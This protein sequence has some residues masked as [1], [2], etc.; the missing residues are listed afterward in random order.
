M[1]D[2]KYRIMSFIGLVIIV[3]LFYIFSSNRKAVNF[4]TIISGVLLQVLIGL[5]I[6]KTDT[7]LMI[8]NGAK[9]VVNSILGYVNEGNSFV[10]GN[11]NDVSKSGF[12]FLV[13]VTGTIIFVGSLM[14][15]LYY[16]GIMKWIIR[17]TAWIMM[18]VMGLSG[19]ESLAAAANIFTGQTEAPL[20]IRPLIGDMTKSELLALMTGGMATIAGG[21]LAAYVGMGIN[22]GHLL[23]ASVMSAPAALVC[24]KLLIPEISHPKT[25]GDVSFEIPQSA[26]NVIDAAADGASAGMKLAINVVAM[27]IAFI[28]LVAL[29]NGLLGYVGGIFGF[30]KLSMQLILGYISAPFAFLMGVPWSDCFNIGSI[31]GT[32]IVL[33]EFVAYVDLAQMVKDG[34][35]TDRGHALATYALCGFA[36]FGSIAI[37][38][39]GISS[40]A[41]HR[42][43]DFA[44]LG[45]K[46]LI[47]GLGACYMTAC[48][49]GM[50]L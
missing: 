22:A 48:V 8:F 11:L 23:A 37:Q 10:F 19:A 42:R 33:N 6:L 13:M 34:L 30:E 20:V 26:S 39:G 17:G 49:A 29:L 7:G 18:K 9:D 3:L 24:A 47:A 32:R 2:F 5:F 45:M 50:F 31:L 15:V 36:N 35:L 43:A 1:E 25:M 44:A 12:I 41:P 14:S 28:A 38:V 16:V 21:V 46:S 40:L 27:L 4:K